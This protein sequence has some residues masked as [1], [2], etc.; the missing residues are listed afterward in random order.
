MD[1]YNEQLEAYDTQ[2]EESQTNIEMIEEEISKLQKYIDESIYMKLE[3]LNIQVSTA[4]YAVTDTV[5]IGYVL[6]SM[7]NYLAYG[8]IQEILE[9]EYGETEASYIREVLSWPTNGNIINITINHYDKEQG[10]KILKTIQD[11][12]ESYIP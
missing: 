10:K 9:K 4:Q 6:T 8:N 5:N 7:T 12:L 1:L 2:I 11:G 3:P